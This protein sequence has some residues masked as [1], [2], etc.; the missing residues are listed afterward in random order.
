MAR[1]TFFYVQPFIR[2]GKGVERGNPYEASN[3]R[4][5]VTRAARLDAKTVGAI[6]FSRTGDPLDGEWDD[7]ATILATYGEVPR[8]DGLG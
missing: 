6:A 7:E 2:K 5:A 3:E 8:E 4:A 1:Q